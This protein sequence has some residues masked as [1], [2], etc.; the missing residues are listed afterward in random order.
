MTINVT[1]PPDNHSEFSPRFP[2][3]YYYLMVYM[4]MTVGLRQAE[5][6]ALDVASIDWQ[7]RTLQIRSPKTRTTRTVQIPLW[8]KRVLSVY[9]KERQSE[10]TA[11][12]KRLLKLRRLWRK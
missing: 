8:L 4:L 1:T 2:E 7:H 9:L 12:K 5:I 3:R 6:L 10:R 11:A